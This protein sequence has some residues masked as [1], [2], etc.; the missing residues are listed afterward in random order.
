MP[1]DTIVNGLNVT[2]LHSNVQAI[3]EQP[4]LARFKLRAH[5]TWVNGS[6]ACSIIKDFYG[7]GG[8]D[9]K[10]KYH[11]VLH[12]DEPDALLGAD[13][14]PGPA[15]TVLHALACCVGSALMF[16]AAVQGVKIDKL[17]FD[18]EGDL[19]IRGFL[20][21]DPD[22]R[23]G[24]ENIRM[25]CRISGDASASK[26]RELVE[27]GQ[28]FSPVYDIVTNGVPVTVVVEGEEVRAAM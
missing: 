12:C 13:Y 23:N 24:F 9:T 7:A 22:V 16:N 11:F 18:V 8:E 14:G 1:E 27:L 4:E 2:R 26:L 15:E 25:S 6:H 17:E 28:K 20:A 21:I 10:R 5:N 19:D 3:K